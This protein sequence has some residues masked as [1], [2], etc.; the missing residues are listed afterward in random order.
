M[1]G[2]KDAS[3]PVNIIGID[4]SPISVARS[5]IIY[6]MLLMGMSSQS[7]FEVWYSSCLSKMAHEDLSKTVQEFLTEYHDPKVTKLLQHW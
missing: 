6:K 2:D 5:L 4:A 3:G 7:I 1:S